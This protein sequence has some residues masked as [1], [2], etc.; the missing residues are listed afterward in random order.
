MPS[1]LAS[2]RTPLS[3]VARLL[4][5]AGLIVLAMP[6]VLAGMAASLLLLLLAFPFVALGVGR[7]PRPM[8][9]V[10]GLDQLLRRWVPTIESPL[11]HS[12]GT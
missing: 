4:A 2:R 10:H 11:S 9:R 6:A 7:R 5:G 1:T 8:L 12:N 3:R